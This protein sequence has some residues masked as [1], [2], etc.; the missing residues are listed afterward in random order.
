MANFTAMMDREHMRRG[1]SLFPQGKAEAFPFAYGAVYLSSRQKLLNEID[2]ARFGF[3]RL[4]AKPFH[5]LCWV[6]RCAWECYVSRWGY[7]GMSIG[8][9]FKLR[10]D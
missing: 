2:V 8:F 7:T 1:K 9:R 4:Y 10:R 3:N 6:I 5:G